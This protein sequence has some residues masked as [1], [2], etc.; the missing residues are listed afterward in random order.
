MVPTLDTL[1]IFYLFKKRSNWYWFNQII[2]VTAM[3]FWPQTNHL[4][5]SLTQ[6]VNAE[7][8]NS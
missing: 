6:L 5:K 4:T 8:Q 7:R 3:K 2:Q 1:H